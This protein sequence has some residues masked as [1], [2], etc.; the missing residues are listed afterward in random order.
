[1][2]RSFCISTGASWHLSPIIS[3]ASGGVMIGRARRY[4]RNSSCAR[5]L[6]KT[7]SILRKSIKALHYGA[8][9]LRSRIWAMENATWREMVVSTFQRVQL[10]NTLDSRCYSK[11]RWRL[12]PWFWSSKILKKHESRV[13]VRVRVLLLPAFENHFLANEDLD[14]TVNQYLVQLEVNGTEKEWKNSLSLS[15][16]FSA[17]CFWL[18]ASPAL[19]FLSVTRPP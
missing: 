9:V 19:S 3:I 12:L 10:R 16:S 5:L 6:T 7:L 13:R 2:L 11:D 8:T 4:D 17:C 18:R 15:L 1:M 14:Q